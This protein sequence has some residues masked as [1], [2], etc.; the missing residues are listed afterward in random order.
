MIPQVSLG[1]RSTWGLSKAV[2]GWP[3]IKFAVRKIF[4]ACLPIGYL[5]S[6]LSYCVLLR[7]ASAVWSGFTC[8]T[9]KDKEIS[10]SYEP[11]GAGLRISKT[12]Q[13]ILVVDDEPQICRR[14]AEALTR[15]G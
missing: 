9:M 12:S 2:C 7:I 6:R 1:M 11:P 8:R 13:R 4:K 5:L 14:C 10:T 3:F 15:H